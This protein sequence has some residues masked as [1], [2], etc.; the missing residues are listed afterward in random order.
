MINGFARRKRTPGSPPATSKGMANW[1]FWLPR[2]LLI[3]GLVF[4]IYWPALSGGFVWDDGWYITTNPLLH[5]SIGLW[6]FWYRPGSWVEYYPI[7]ETVLW[8]QWQL[9]GKATLG[10]HLTN[11][12]LHILNALLVWRLL[13]KFKLKWAWL[14]GLIFAVHPVQV[15]S[16]AWIS[17]LKSTLSMPFFL[18]AMGY[19]M[20]YE[21]HQRRED[22]QAS[23]GL[24]LLGM[25][26][27]ITLAPFPFIILLYAWWKRG[28]IAWSDVKN[29]LPFL[30]ISLALGFLTIWVGHAYERHG[31]VV[32]IEA[33]LGSFAAQVANAGF[34]LAFYFANCF[35]PADIAPIYPKWTIDPASP[36]FYFPTLIAVG[37]VWIMWSKRRSWGRHVLLG[38]GFFVLIL[39]PFLGF[40]FITYMKDSWVE[41]HQLYLPVLGVIGLF[42]A[43]WGHLEERL[44]SSKRPWMVGIMTVVMSCAVW[45][46]HAYAGWFVSE[47]TF[48]TRTLQRSP[49][50]WLPHY[51]LGCDYL[52]QGRLPEAVAELQRAI[53][54]LP[55]FGDG[56]SNLGLAMSK[57]GKKEEARQ[58]YEKDLALNPGDGKA[59][60]NLADSYLQDGQPTEAI[61]YYRKALPLLP[62]VSQLRYDLG[63]V[64]LQSGQ[65]PE[66]I[67]QLSAAV[68]IDPSMAQAHENLGSA[69]AQSGALPDAIGQFEAAI[70]IRPDYV[71]A[72]SNLALALTQSGR[73]S[74]AIDQFQ[75]I[76]TIDPNNV[77]ARE[78]LAKLQQ[79][80]QS[81]PKP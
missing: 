4:L 64:L 45:K 1:P 56:Y 57:M 28:C 40:H 20:D 81:H 78:S 69:L 30:V 29:A 71:L 50:A 43:G 33:P 77:N 24:F 41:L 60:V 58:L 48:W 3:V 74:E 9:W 42:V 21:D 67:D 75:Q 76:L 72:R 47:D 23:L 32:E 12:F 55:A 7:H 80:L 44:S 10:Y 26:C 22:Y 52:Q 62:E 2:F 51:N 65:L 63:N 19:W 59:Y 34:I 37:I 14:G 17:E 11:V 31:H 25:L 18:L 70:Q 6:K 8:I 79:Y 13:G 46:A 54:L 5:S 38:L 73:I 49:N 36:L 16:V 61:Q 53:D 15:E 35:L 39:G 68:K 66:A 27:K